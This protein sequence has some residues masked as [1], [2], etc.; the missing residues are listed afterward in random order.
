MK[1]TFII[2]FIAVLPVAACRKEQK[3]IEAAHEMQQFVIEISNYAKAIDPDFLIIPQNGEALCYTDANPEL[4]FVT[5]YLDAIDGIGVEEIF[6]NGDLA[7][8]SYRLNMLRQLVVSEKIMVS[9]YVNDDNLM[10]DAVQQNLAEG[11]LCFPRSS[12]NYN[13]E[14]IPSTVTNENADSIVTL[15]QAKNYLYLISNSQFATKQAMIDAI[16]ATNFDLVILDLFFEEEPFTAAEIDQL[17]TKA[18]GGQ[19]LV[20]AYMSIGSAENYR[21][22]WQDKWRLHKPNWLKKKYDG[23]KDEIWVEYWDQEWKDIIYGNDASYLK[24]I[25]DAGF[26]GVYLDNVEAYYFLYHRN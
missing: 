5:T 10:A 11:F 15:Q 3:T 6:Y 8:D 20:I 24:K 1:K 14:F 21:Y 12:S 23:Y 9:E 22:Y 16:A 4:A 26:D 7:I 18:N 19:R 25:L 13:Y 17:K 2:L